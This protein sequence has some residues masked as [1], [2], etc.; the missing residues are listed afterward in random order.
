MNIY[1]VENQHKIAAQFNADIAAAK[2]RGNQ[3]T[4]EFERSLQ[5][6][7]QHS[8]GSETPCVTVRNP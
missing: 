8:C 2:A 6:A 4:P 3:T 1:M 7:L 5:S